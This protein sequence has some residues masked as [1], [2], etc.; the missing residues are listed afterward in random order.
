[1]VI[2]EA[3]SLTIIIILR[4]DRSTIAPANG[5]AIS[6]GA[7]KKK[8]SIARAVAELVFWYAQIVTAKP[9]IL[10]PSNEMIWPTQTMEKPNI[11]VGRF[12]DLSAVLIVECLSHKKNASVDDSR[13]SLIHVDMILGLI[14]HQFKGFI[15]RHLSTLDSLQD[16]SRAE[17]FRCRL[18]WR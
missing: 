11:P 6:M 12:G 3:R 18:N 7:T 14:L 10:V 2:P 9:V 4:L 5:D 17:W 15:H 8:P 13:A 1:M 16:F